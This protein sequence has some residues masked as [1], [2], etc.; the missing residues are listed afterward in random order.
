MPGRDDD[1]EDSGG[2]EQAQSANRRLLNAIKPAASQAGPREVRSSLPKVI[3]VLF[4]LAFL[5]DRMFL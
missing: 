4:H 2:N 1:V 5:R 3:T